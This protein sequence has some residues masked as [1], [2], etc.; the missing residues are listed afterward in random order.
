[1]CFPHLRQ[2]DFKK[3]GVAVNVPGSVHGDPLFDLAV[4]GSS[5]RPEPVTVPSLLLSMTGPGPLDMPSLLRQ[6]LGPFLCMLRG[7]IAEQ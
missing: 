6:L 1:M 7:V 5:R 3:T 4:F 2:R